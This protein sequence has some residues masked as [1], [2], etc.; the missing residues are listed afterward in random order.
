ML[1]QAV[2]SNIS[3]LVVAHSFIMFQLTM[4]LNTE[5]LSMMKVRGYLKI[6]DPPCSGNNDLQKLQ[7][8]FFW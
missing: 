1:L 8:I 6:S 7:S 3:E 4:C 5:L 2:V